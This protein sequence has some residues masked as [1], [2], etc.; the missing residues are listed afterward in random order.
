MISIDTFQEIWATV[1]K[2]KMRTF[3]TA[4]SVAWGIFLL[5]FLIGTGTGFKN[6]VIWEFRDD[7]A[8]TL[9]INPGTTSLAH[10][11]MSSG[12]NIRFTDEDYKAIKA[13]IP[14]VRNLTARYFVPGNKVVTYQKEKASFSVRAVHPDHKIMENT[15]MTDGR[16]I[17]ERDVEEKRKI[18]VIGQKVQ[19]TLF[20]DE[21]PL[22]EWINISGIMYK[23]VGVYEDVGGEGEMSIIYLPISTAQM[24]YGAANNV[25]A[26]LLGMD[27]DD[28]EESLQ[29]QQ[30]TLELMARRHH[31][32]ADD[33]RAIRM[34]NLLQEFQQVIG[35]IDAINIALVIVGVFTI[36]AGIVGVGNIM[37]IVVKERTREIGVRKALGATPFSIV[38]LF[39]QE[40]ILITVLAG[41]FG[42]I[43]GLGLIEGI[44]ALLIQAGGG[45][46]FFRN[47][48]VD[49][50][51]A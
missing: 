43:A 16:Y 26:F 42:L 5:V 51:A 29:I 2:N 13:Q 4:F 44:Q 6:G 45:V 36:V 17:N 41:Y 1:R 24:A 11:G 49:V 47:P 25:D 14:K 33:P 34:F 38:S 39:M 7:A 9:F 21:N 10:D 12:R 30:T 20:R 28:V 27:T 19:E 46:Q 35:L 37:L 3:L 18:A 50:D 23:V 22:G 15:L 32:A 40:A 31:F 48:N 8:N